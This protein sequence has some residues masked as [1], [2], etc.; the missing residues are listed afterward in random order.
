[1]EIKPPQIKVNSSG[2][3]INIKSTVNQWR[4][5]EILNAMVVSRPKSDSFILKVGTDTL[6][7]TGK[8]PAQITSSLEAGTKLKLEV[9]QTT[10]QLTLKVIPTTTS[11]TTNALK[12]HLPKQTSL[13]PL[14]ANIIAL[15]QSSASSQLPANLA[16]SIENL[17]KALPSA[18]DVLKGNAQTMQ[19]VLKESGIFLERH[20]SEDNT[21]PT[22]TQILNADFKANLLKVLQQLRSYQKQAQVTPKKTSEP[23]NNIQPQ[24]LPLQASSTATTLGTSIQSTS[25]PPESFVPPQTP[26]AAP[27]LKNT[28]IQAQARSQ[29]TLSQATPLT[30]VI[31]ELSKQIE[32]AISRIRV[33]QLANIPSDLNQPLSLNVEL[34]VRRE[35]GIDLFQLRIEEDEE[36]G[37][38]SSNKAPAWKVTLAFHFDELGPVYANISVFEETVSTTLHAELDKTSKLINDNLNT[39]SKDLSEAGLNVKKLVCLTGKPMHSFNTR[40]FQ[41][42]LDIKA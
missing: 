17:L 27:T 37:K 28:A 29:P 21:S 26:T 41:S 35:S 11:A 20:L 18:Q 6:Q 31:E 16:K 22:R 3:S 7:A 34:P 12:Q 15:S 32:G 19:R 2:S 14:L 30:F 33:T 10:P 24:R 23:Y 5:G 9:L 39:L 38:H 1:M 36:N 25:R 8:P 42:I 40:I 4:T 13:T